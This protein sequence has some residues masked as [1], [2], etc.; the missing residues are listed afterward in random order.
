LRSREGGI[1]VVGETRAAGSAYS[2]TINPI[3]CIDFLIEL[4]EC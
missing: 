1:I 4:R 3:R 2:V